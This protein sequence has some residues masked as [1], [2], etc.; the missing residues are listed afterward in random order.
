M[1]CME[2]ARPSTRLTLT[3]GMEDQVRVLHSGT[4]YRRKATVKSLKTLSQR[5]EKRATCVEVVG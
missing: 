2:H 3:N 1:W 5:G 4:V